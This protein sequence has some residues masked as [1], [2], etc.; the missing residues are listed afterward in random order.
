[1]NYMKEKQNQ[2]QVGYQKMIFYWRKASWK[3]RDFSQWGSTQE[4][5]QNY[6]LSCETL[7]R[8]RS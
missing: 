8:S 4:I 3:P 6:I 7:R 1:M 2:K 5:V